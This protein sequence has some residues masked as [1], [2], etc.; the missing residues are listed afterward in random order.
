[1][2][3]GLE[4]PLEGSAAAAFEDPAQARVRAARLAGGSAQ[5]AGRLLGLLASVPDPDGALTA[6]ERLAAA[7]PLPDGDDALRALLLIFGHSPYLTEI[8]LGAPP[9]F[10]EAWEA[11]RSPAP[12]SEQHLA[13]LRA[14]LASASADAS[15]RLLR[16]YKERGVLAVALRDFLREWSL[17]EVTEQLSH[18]ADAVL[19]VTLDAAVRAM[20][21]R[22]GAPAE[23]DEEGRRRRAACALIGLGKLGGMELNYSSDV[24]LL[25]LY[26][27]DGETTGSGRDGGGVVTTKEFFTRAGEEMTRRLGGAGGD[28]WILRVDWG[29]RPGG[30]DGDLTLPLDAALAY[31]RTWARP[32]ERQALIKARFVAGDPGL[33]RRFAEAVEPLAYPPAADPA[34]AEAIRDLK[35][36]MDAALAA[37]GAGAAHLKLGR[38]G[39]REIEFNVQARQ[40]L[41]AGRDP[42][43][44]ER[45]TLRA[46]HRLA[47]RGRLSR[48]E[49][50]A[51]TA[52]YQ[53]LR[54]AEH[55]I[56]IRRNLQR[57]SLPADPRELR[58][59]GRAMGFL[60]PGPGRETESFLAALERHRTEVRTLY[61]AYFAGLAQER[62]EEAPPAD[63]FL[64]EMKGAAALEALEAAGLAEPRDLLG[65]VRRIARLLQP[66]AA[67]PEIR[68]EFRRASPMVLR[69]V[70]ALPNPAR[71]LRCLEA[72]MESLAVEA[73]GM[74][75]FLERRDLLAPLLQLFSGSQPL[76]G[77]VIHRPRLLLGHAFERAP[78]AERSLDQHLKLMRGALAACGSHAE[79]LAALRLYQQAET[80]RIGLRDLSHQLTLRGALRALS[81]LAEASVR[82]ALQAAWES[83]AP[84]GAPPPRDFCVLGLGRLGY[85]EM[86]Y[87]SDLDLVFVYRAAAD[88][89]AA[90]VQAG[91][92]A[93]RMVDALA[94][95]TR[96]GPLYA[97]DTRLRPFGS[98]GE[99][100]QSG[101]TLL[102]YLETQAG[103]WEM[104]SYLKARPVAGDLRFGGRLLRRAE[105][106]L[107]D[108]ARREPLAAAIRSMR[109]R[110]RE[111]APAGASDFRSGAGGVNTVQFTLQ[112]LQL[113][114]HV[115]SPSRKS[116]S[117]L[118]RT[119]RDHGLLDDDRH[120]ALFRGHQFLR[121]LEHQ[122][123]LIQGRAVTCVPASADVLLEVA[124]ALGYPQD[125][126][127]EATSALIEDLDARRG[128]VERAYLHL[129]PES[130]AGS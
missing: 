108:R 11:R 60:E 41:H 82:G 123:R 80:L 37:R 33:G 25:L 73:G 38:G 19:A 12:T 83:A 125:D 43:L 61:D 126:P 112:Y 53:F 27:G 7:A 92:L 114:H 55:R 3:P 36:R 98:E 15:G 102:R 101:E 10:S 90:H 113:R 65:H 106:M 74:A 24:D 58:V 20:E 67:G 52:A 59:L 130:D 105:R 45:N 21:E 9:L 96:E 127:R 26:S 13:W 124:R 40:I 75:R 97:V 29:L 115:P 64:D 93:A 77:L 16:R 30:R 32:W 44:R 79:R 78:A 128:E 42:W 121:R 111:A 5:A 88:D 6:A 4:E 91:D 18:L 39:I 76:A 104:Q 8:I 99:L 56:Q 35:D 120:R 117:R 95:I 54:E 17:T 2:A 68:R 71:T 118:L 51:L 14:E 46:L 72:L 109:E 23:E 34:V 28:G 1:L 62:F 89:A 50:S 31:Y 70:A 110:L 107:L 22:F 87:G 119:L 86:D 85:R 63:P 47:D 48:S 84:G 49:H 57:A 122:I 116:T 129:V 100:A 94:S 81:D 66:P 69:Q 103:V